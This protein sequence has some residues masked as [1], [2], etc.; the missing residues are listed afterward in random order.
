MTT[1]AGWRGSLDK[2]L[3][4]DCTG[5]N[6]RNCWILWCWSFWNARF[7]ATQKEQRSRRG[8]QELPA[9]EHA[10]VLARRMGGRRVVVVVLALGIGIRGDQRG[11]QVISKTGQQG[12][13]VFY[14][15]S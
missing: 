9:E 11:L 8:T 6:R 2:K 7:E 4:I 3:T 5:C 1:A 12:M 13:Q 10:N 15:P 14:A